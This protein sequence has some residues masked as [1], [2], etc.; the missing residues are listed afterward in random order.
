MQSRLLYEGAEAVTIEAYPLQWPTGRPRTARWE[1]ERAAFETTFAR[2]RDDITH[3]VALLTGISTRWG[4]GP[5]VVISTNTALRRDGLPLAGQKN[6]DDPGVAVYFKYKGKPMSFA[7]DRW[8]RIE[9]NM[10]AIVKTI[11]A[12]RGIARW[13]TGD[14]LEA[15]FTGF[16]ALPAPGAERPWYEVLGFKSSNVN[17]DAIRDAYRRLR[18]EH[19]PDKGGS[20]ARFDEVERAYREATSST[21]GS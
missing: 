17:S 10:R 3:E 2:S 15:A 13:G 1:R 18:S 11:E 12:L 9:H 14:M 8:D 16:V 19:H 7:C 4:V 21:K 5:E 20:A 6:P